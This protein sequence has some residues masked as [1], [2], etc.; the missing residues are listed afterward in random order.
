VQETLMLG[1]GA[2]RLGRAARR[3][4]LHALALKTCRKIGSGDQLF[5][6]AADHRE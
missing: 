2:A 6:V 4:R 1:I 5:R 3:E